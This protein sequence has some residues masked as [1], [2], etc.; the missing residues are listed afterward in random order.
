MT[1]PVSE[2]HIRERLDGTFTRVGGQRD[3]VPLDF[4]PTHESFEGNYQGGPHLTEG[5]ALAILGHFRRS[6]SYTETARL[7]G[8]DVSTVS[9]LARGKTWKHL[10]PARHG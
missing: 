10:N 4:I 5:E 3:L 6:A 7:F 1:M 8:V 2:A 9:N